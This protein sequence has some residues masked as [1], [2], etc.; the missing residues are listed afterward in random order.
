METVSHCFM[1]S[2]GVVKDLSDY[3]LKVQ[4]CFGVIEVDVS[5]F[6]IC[7]VF[8]QIWE[9]RRVKVRFVFALFVV[10]N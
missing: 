5:T 7:D 8:N 4:F 2:S 1:R 10:S 9:Q 6:V 3:S